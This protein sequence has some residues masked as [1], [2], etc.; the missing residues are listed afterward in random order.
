LF[1]D[2]LYFENA[3]HADIQAMK[4]KKAFTEAKIPFLFESFTN[5]QFPILTQEQHKK[6]SENFDYETWEPLDDDKIAVRFVTSW[7]TTDDNVDRLIKAIK[8]L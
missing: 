6:L 8:A 7:A 4:I 1:E 5:Q 2:D 3:R